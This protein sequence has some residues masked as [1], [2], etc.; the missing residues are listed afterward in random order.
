MLDF[1]LCLPI[2]NNF[3]LKYCEFWQALFLQDTNKMKEIAR[4]WGVLDEEIFASSILMRPYKSN[5][6]LSQE[7]TKEEVYE[8]QFKLK[9]DMKK[10]M[11]DM[12]RFPKDIMFIGRNMTLV[13]S[14]NKRQKFFF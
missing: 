3:R 14:L 4:G 6:P 7:I 2:E 9:Q 8:L 10:M 1:G 5:K 13:R 11:S 12:D